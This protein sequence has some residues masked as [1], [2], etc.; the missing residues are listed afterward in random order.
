MNENYTK[1][2]RENCFNTA[3]VM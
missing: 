3:T 2:N 1:K